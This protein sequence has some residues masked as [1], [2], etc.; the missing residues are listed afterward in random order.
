MRIYLPPIGFGFTSPPRS[1]YTFAAF[2]STRALRPLPAR[3]QFATTPPPPF[4]APLPLLP[5]GHRRTPGRPAASQLRFLLQPA[6]AASAHQAGR[7]FH[8]HSISTLPQP[9]L[10]FPFTSC[11]IRTA[12]HSTP[13]SA[14]IVSRRAATALW[15]GRALAATWLCFRYR[16]VSLLRHATIFMRL[17]PP[18]LLFRRFNLIFAGQPLCFSGFIRHSNSAHSGIILFAACRSRNAH[19]AANFIYS[20]IPGIPGHSQGHYSG[21]GFAIPAPPFGQAFGIGWAG[22]GV[23]GLAAGPGHRDPGLFA[24]YCRLIYAIYYRHSLYSRHSAIFHA[25]MRFDR[26]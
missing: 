19:A 12:G 17:L 25:V 16:A 14:A 4:A 8:F 20:P 1:Q 13:R 21:P 7:R 9:L 18:G 23:C 26:S 15:P 24:L 22:L 11:H 6:S 3:F 2:H 10:P 5:P